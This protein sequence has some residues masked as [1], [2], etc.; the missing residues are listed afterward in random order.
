MKISVAFALLLIGGLL[1]ASTEAGAVVYC[2]NVD[3]PSGCLVAPRAVHR[4]IESGGIPLS[5]GL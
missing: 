2:K 3:Y 5:G 1:A 4:L